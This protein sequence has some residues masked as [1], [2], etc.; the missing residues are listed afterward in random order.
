[1][2]KGRVIESEYHPFATPIGVINLFTEYLSVGY[3]Y[4]SKKT[5]NTCYD[6][7]LPKE[8]NITLLKVL[9]PTTNLQE[10]KEQKSTFETP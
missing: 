1:M 5:Q 10:K 9:D 4:H 3:Y 2:N 8:M 6:V 7:V